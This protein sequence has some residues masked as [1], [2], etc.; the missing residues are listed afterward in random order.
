MTQMKMS[1]TDLAEFV[2]PDTARE[3]V[4][5][6]TEPFRDMNLTRAMEI[7]DSIPAATWELFHYAYREAMEEGTLAD[8]LTCVHGCWNDR[9]TRIC[10]RSRAEANGYPLRGEAWD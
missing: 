10:I 7:I 6:G 3:Q 8:F 1:E 5:S 9:I 2:G 4:G